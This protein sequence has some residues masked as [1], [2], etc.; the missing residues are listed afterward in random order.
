MYL[1]RWQERS[2]ILFSTIL[3]PIDI[4]PLQVSWAASPEFSQ[5]F[6]Q[7]RYWKIWFSASFSSQVSSV[8]YLKKRWSKKIIKNYSI[9]I[10]WIN[11]ERPKKCPFHSDFIL[12]INYLYNN[13]SKI[14]WF[15][16]ASSSNRSDLFS[17]RKPIDHQI[18]YAIFCIFIAL[19]QLNSARLIEASTFFFFIKFFFLKSTK[20]TE[21]INIH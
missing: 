16:C 20:N 6:R 10:K 7:S 21:S 18:G 2:L 9:A 1:Q 3:S 17:L 15:N 12:Q 11:V 5:V 4:S 19:H 8:K 14:S 13:V